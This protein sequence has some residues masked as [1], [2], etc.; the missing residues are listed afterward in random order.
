MKR[1]KMKIRPAIEPK[2]RHLIENALERLGYSVDGGGSDTD[3]TECDISF[4]GCSITKG[5]K[6]DLESK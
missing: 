5:D 1:Y 6:D 3:G 4:R 2:D